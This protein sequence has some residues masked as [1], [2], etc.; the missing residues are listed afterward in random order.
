MIYSI[1][2]ILI[3][4]EWLWGRVL[5]VLDIKASHW[6]LPASVEDIYDPDRY[7]RQQQYLRTNARFGWFYS[8]INMLITVV[9][10]AAG[11]FG[12]LDGIVSGWAMGISLSWLPSEAVAAALF[13]AGV[14]LAT[15][16]IRW[17][18]SYYDT[19]VIEQSF[20]FNK[21]TRLR[22]VRDILTSLLLNIVL[23]TLIVIPLVVIYLAIPQWFWLAAL[24][25]VLVFQLFFGEFYSV[26]IVPLFNKQT[27]LADGEL[28]SAIERFAVRADF[29]IKG[30]YVM[31]ASSRTTKA[32]AYFTG[33][34]KQKRIVLYDT[35][36]EQL[37]TDEI[38]AVLA[39]EIGHYKH[40][41][42]WK[43][44]ASGALQQMVIFFLMGLCLSS[45][46]LA[47]AAGAS[48]PSFHVN[49]LMFSFI[50]TPASI[51]L[52]MLDNV[53]SRRHEYQADA[54][55][56][57]FGMAEPLIS[58]LKK[59]TSQA[60]GN[61]NPHPVRV[62]VDYSHPTLAQRIERLRANS[63]VSK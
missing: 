25:V 28:R 51:L 17:P 4:G 50:F 59:I 30:I 33:F 7:A 1:I 37:T 23:T 6:A 42:T 52:G 31:D 60:M 61:L 13:F 46:S 5:S 18:F 40:R 63:E 10:F 47:S 27:P 22:F 20:G 41:H 26:L 34:G 49:M 53:L 43:S 44:L 11:G 8:T 36:I 57:Q 2:L 32:N 21:S 29:S 16:I 19:F 39:H 24:G 54:F 58:A 55:A 48:E 35:L 14:S 12:W 15:S 56:A 3:V 9:F 45:S 62:F 38:V